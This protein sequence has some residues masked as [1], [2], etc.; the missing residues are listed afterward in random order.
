LRLRTI[1]SCSSSGHEDDV[2]DN[3][4]D[5]VTIHFKDGS[6]QNGRLRSDLL[7]GRTLR[8][9]PLSSA[10][11]RR[12]ERRLF[13]IKE[14]RVDRGKVQR[15]SDLSSLGLFV[16][17]LTVHPIGAVVPVELGAGKDTIRLKGRVV[18][19]DPGIGS[20]L[21]FDRPSTKLRLKLEGVLER[22]RRAA[23]R[24]EAKDRRSGKER[25]A[26][27]S[28][29]PKKHHRARARD[30]R[31]PPEADGK[32]REIRL[33]DIKAVFFRKGLEFSRGNGHEGT[34]EFRDG[35]NLTG[36]FYDPSPESGGI[37]VEIRVAPDLYYK[38]FVNK[39]AI[40]TLEYL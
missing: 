32:P 8:F 27:R 25:R 10:R 16:E 29:S 35:E 7:V 11:D 22:E 28:G 6:V 3:R 12:G 26:A 38:M 40:K 9:E 5:S 23:E 14:V 20:G 18:F 13:I 21:E 17:S 33:S 1:E 19:N 39:S 37:F 36:R 2:T 24:F 4:S 34:I 31:S 30:R 15:T